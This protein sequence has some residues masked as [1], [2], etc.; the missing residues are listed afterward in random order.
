MHEWDGDDPVSF[1]SPID[2]RI[3][4]DV[5]FRGLSHDAQLVW[6]RLLTGPHVTPVAGLWPA[7]EEQLS[8]AFGFSVDAFLAIFA[9]LSTT[10]GKP[11]GKVFADWAAGVIWFPNALSVPANQPK[12]ENVLRGWV[13]HLELVPECKLRDKALLEIAKWVLANPQRFPDGLP[14]GFPKP[15]GKP[16]R[17]PFGEHVPRANQDQEQEQEQEQE[18]DSRGRL[19]PPNLRLTEDQIGNAQMGLGAK[20]WQIEAMCADL[21][22]KWCDGETRRASLAHWRRQLWVAF[23]TDWK[24]ETK[25][26]KRADQPDPA[27]LAARR[28]RD[29]MDAEERR[30]REAEAGAGA[31]RP[32]QLDPAKAQTLKLAL[33]GIGG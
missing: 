1:Y 15:F 16:F 14:Q 23:S 4:A 22:G 5:W 11:N 32:S 3:N 19:C 12:N 7:T 24:N 33:A 28:A 20:R 18:P 26:P 25:R 29:A 30:R 17:E 21:V 10:A 8:R 6:F 13:K 27:V 31:D 9:E 2:R